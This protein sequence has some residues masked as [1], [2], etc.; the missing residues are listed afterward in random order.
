MR[1]CG[2]PIIKQGQLFYLH[3]NDTSMI[4]EEQFGYLFLK[5]FGRKVEKY[6]GSNAVIW[7]DHAFSGNPFAEQRE[8]SM[9]TQRHVLGQHGLGDFRECSIRIQHG[10]NDLTDFRYHD[11]EIVAGVVESDGLPSPYAHQQDAT[12]LILTLIDEVAHLELKLH[13]TVYN[14][15]NTITT[16]TTLTNRS[17][18]A[19]VVHKLLSTLLDLPSREYDTM[20]FQGAYAR[21][22]T[23]C[24][25][26]LGQGLHQISSTRGASGHGQTPSLIIAEPSTSEDFGEA[27]AIQLMYSGNFEA[28]AQV[29]QLNELRVA[30]GINEANFSWELEKGETFHTPVALLTFTDKGLDQLSHESHQFIREHIMNPHFTKRERPIL[31]NNW[32][33]TYFDFDQSKLVSLAD[34]ASEVG[35]E[36]FVLDDGWFGNR[37]DDNRALGDWKVNEAKI[38]G[39]L[40]NLISEIKG[41]G[42]K[43]GIWIEPEMIS[44]DSDLYRQHPE[45]VIQVPKRAHTYSRNQL[46]LNYANPAVIDYMKHIFDQLLSEH[47]IDYVKWDMNRNITNI[48]NGMTYQETQMQSH[49]Y[50]L[51]LYEL[52][53]YLTE[54]HS[55]ILFESCSGGGGRNDLGMMRYFPQV[56]SSDNTDAIGRLVIQHGSSFLY[57][58]ISMGAH[59]SAAP[60]HQMNRDTSLQTRGDVAMMGNLGYELDLSQLTDGEKLEVKQQ[61]ETYKLLRPIVQFGRPFRLINPTDASNETAVQFVYEDQVLLTY[62]KVLSTIETMETTVKLK[63]LEASVLYQLTGTDERFSGAELMYAGYTLNIPQGDFQ[64]MQLLFKRCD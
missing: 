48:G 61:V 44:E 63:G 64:T 11:Y 52:V 35:I 62:V 60:N 4:I 38:G 47:D 32:E 55:D 1:R 18:E 43:F 14:K 2:M 58:V 50:M 24:R 36:L 5:H 39:S 57:P 31:I 49:R 12:T 9:D 16:F 41:K 7:K 33:A 27:F 53:A 28:F 30:I 25:H 21:E 46:V 22:K 37:S 59:V 54:K 23:Y 45:W 19:V 6:H 51:G 29:N 10:N 15:Q 42:L 34:Q 17:N 13:Y 3:S 56:W 26:T 8:F 20:T 40:A